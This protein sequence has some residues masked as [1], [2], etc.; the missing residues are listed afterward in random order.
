VIGLAGPR[1]GSPGW[2]LDA[3]D[4]CRATSGRPAS[5]TL[6]EVMNTEVPY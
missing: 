6:G 5:V 2:T 4:F 3:T 1:G